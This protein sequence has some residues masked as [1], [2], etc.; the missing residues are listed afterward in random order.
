M[1]M[2]TPTLFRTALALALFGCSLA[3]HA[4]VSESEAA[5]LGQDLTPMGAEKAGNADG[6]IPP[7]DPKG[8]PTPPKFVAGSDNYVSPWPDEKP[9]YTIDGSNWKLVSWHGSDTPVKK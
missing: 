6:S 8:T 7:W 4:R 5:R 9:L 1:S 3:S 2:I